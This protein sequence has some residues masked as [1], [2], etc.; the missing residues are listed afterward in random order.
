[1]IKRFLALC[2][3]GL[4]GA[5]TQTPVTRDA[6]VIVV[7][8]G[9]AGL[10]AALE[11]ADNG[12]RVLLLE[13]N[14]VGGG[15]AVKAGGFALVDTALQRSRGIQ[16]SPQLA[17]ADWI[18]YGVDPD[19]LWTNRYAEASSEEVYDWLTEHGTEFRMLLP[20]PQDRVQRVH[21]TRGAAV[22][23]VVPL[24]R[25]MIY[26]PNIT[27]RWNTRVVALARSGG[28]INGV[29]ARDERDGSE[30]LFRSNSVILATGGLQNNLQQVRANWSADI[31]EPDRLFKGAG[32]FATGDGYRMANWAGAEL[33]NMDRQVI[34]YN[35]VPNPR[36]STG[37]KALLTQNPRAIWV[38][39]A[40][41]RF[42]NE[43]AGDKAV[44]Q[45]M[46]D[47]PAPGYWMIFDAEG[48]KRLTLRGALWL[49]RDT[50]ATE[51]LHNPLV[52]TAADNLQQLASRTGL[53]EQGLRATVETW[54]RM[55]EVGEDFKFG[56]FSKQ[57]PDRN[58]VP[59]SKAPFYAVRTR[60][61]TRK[62]LGGPAINPK[63]QALNTKGRPVAGLYAAGELTGVAGIN[64]RYGG[65]GTFLGPSV[66]TGRIAGATAAKASQPALSYRKLPAVEYLNAPHPGADGYWHFDVAHKLVSERGYS[67][68]KCHSD[69]NPMQPASE[70]AVLLAR[71]D[72]CI[73]C[74]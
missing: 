66:Y 2:A 36:D 20:T 46:T 37:K 33:V 52:V 44:T 56:R 21:F 40:G 63:A 70:R 13:V 50:V 7:G 54:N 22:N 55:V 53:P 74:H 42:M 60:P 9:I 4:L 48:A 28:R 24:L 35:G 58:A 38:D 34:F 31:Q 69:T 45:A 14:A 16:D 11:A 3:A 57:Q 73:L 10:S 39:S 1:L 59:V 29:L 23:A 18:A 17:V 32:K 61:M 68:T 15:H 30:H 65:A 49:N 72:T 64:G 41:H 43:K 12:A 5:C 51:I 8:A 62:N 25:S 47:N 27:F 67:C 19:P 6:D 71:L 26:N